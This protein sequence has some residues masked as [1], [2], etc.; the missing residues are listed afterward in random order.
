MKK[1]LMFILAGILCAVSLTS[2][3][4]SAPSSEK[5]A[6]KGGGGQEKMVVAV[7]EAQKGFYRMAASKYSKL[8]PETEIEIVEVPDKGGAYVCEGLAGAGDGGQGAGCFSSRRK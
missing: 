2:C 3:N 1:K 6:A 4:S 7:S 5:E 8:H